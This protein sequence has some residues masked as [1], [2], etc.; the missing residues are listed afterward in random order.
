MFSGLMQGIAP[1][2]YNKVYFKNCRKWE[3]KFECTCNAGK[4]NYCLKPGETKET[5]W[6]C[7]MQ[8]VNVMVH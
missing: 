2:A 1:G 8:G 7:V 3:V 6:N 4:Y 5:S